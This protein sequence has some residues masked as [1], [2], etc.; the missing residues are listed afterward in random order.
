VS[1][2]VSDI[3]NFIEIFSSNYISFVNDIFLLTAEGAEAAEEEKRE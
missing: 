2:E 3:S 1:A